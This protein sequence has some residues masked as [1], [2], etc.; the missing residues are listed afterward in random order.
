MDAKWLPPQPPAANAL[1]FVAGGDAE[2]DGFKRQPQVHQDGDH[3]A[4]PAGVHDVLLES[5]VRSI[6]TV[7]HSRLSYRFAPRR[8]SPDYISLGGFQPLHFLQEH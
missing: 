8:V 3:A 4:D 2:D 7:K 5:R 6:K 1:L